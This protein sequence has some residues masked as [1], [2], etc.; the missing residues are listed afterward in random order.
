MVNMIRF[1][2][3]YL[4]VSLLFL[5]CSCKEGEIAAL[6]TEVKERGPELEALKKNLSRLSD[7]A[8]A[9]TN[10]TAEID[11][12]IRNLQ[13]H[14]QAELEVA[15]QFNDVKTYQNDL[16]AGEALLTEQLEVWKAATR[17]SLVGR[18]VETVRLNDGRILSNAVILE[19]TDKDVNFQHDGKET[20]AA[21][22]E[23]SPEL[24]D[25]FVDEEMILRK[26]RIDRE[27]K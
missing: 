17:K 20:R 22:A 27:S 1:G 16:K 14:Q 5:L 19:V 4:F 24:R 26:I 8:R 21:L 25:Q 18:S 10:K 15:K 3:A 12:S 2:Q 9:I 23:L 6:E 11:G 7:E 13:R